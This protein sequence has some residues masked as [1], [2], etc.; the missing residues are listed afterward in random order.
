MPRVYYGWIVVATLCLTETVSWGI[1]YYGFPVFLRPM[2]E[3]LGASRLAVTGAFSL[4]LGVSAV[5]ALPVGRWLDRH[6]PWALMTLGSVLGTALVLAWSRVGSLAELYLVWVLLGL[7]MAATLYEPAF[8]AVVQWFR[9]GRRDMALTTVTLVAAL[10]STIFMPI[11]AWLLERLGWR[12]ALVVLAIVLGTLTIPLHAVVLRRRAPG[13]ERAAAGSGPATR[14]VPG[15]T[16]AEARRTPIFWAL[17]AAFV[18]GNFATI[19]VTVHLIPY[20]TDRGWSAPLA[21]SVIGWMGAMQVPGRVLFAA[22]VS[23]LGADRV[24]AA[25]FVAQAAGIASL[26][27]ATSIPGGLAATVFLLGAANGMSTLARAT[28]IAELF[29]PR[30]YATISGAVA[31][32]ANG[33]RAIGPVG[34]SL[35]YLAL[36]GYERVF[37]LLAVALGVSAVA[38]VAASRQRLPLADAAASDRSGAP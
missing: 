34:A 31:L 3:A 30:Y 32:G 25:V 21:A 23:R 13:L 37:T 4:S 5:A 33:A 20:L 15:L 9:T 7:A 1:V 36:G 35:L 38:M 27:L 2:E 22:I 18:V 17:T 6:G 19:S 28:C 26:T 16:L 24:A 29:G 10:A 11:A 14:P 12:T 8:G